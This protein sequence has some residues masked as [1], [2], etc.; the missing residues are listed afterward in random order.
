MSQMSEGGEGLTLIG[1]LSQIFSF[2][3]VTS[4]LYCVEFLTF[5]VENGNIHMPNF[6]NK[7]RMAIFVAENKLSAFSNPTPDNSLDPTNEDFH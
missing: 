4:P 1:T 2:F 7:K 3:L 5:L 6:E